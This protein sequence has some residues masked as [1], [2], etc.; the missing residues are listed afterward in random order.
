[1]LVGV[2]NVAL[3]GLLLSLLY[4]QALLS[5]ATSS[6][7]VNY[8]LIIITALVPGALVIGT[9]RALKRT[10]KKYKLVK[11]TPTQTDD[12]GYGSN[13]G[14]SGMPAKRN[15][16]TDDTSDDGNSSEIGPHQQPSETERQTEDRDQTT[17]AEIHIRDEESGSG[18]HT[19][20]Q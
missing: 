5:G 19:S 15:A 8:I 9:K 16:Q 7:V 13:D 11:E 18:E 10:K 20:G 2:F 6:T 14:D 4:M 17:T 1:M 12:T 3:V